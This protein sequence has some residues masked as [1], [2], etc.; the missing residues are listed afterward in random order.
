MVRIYYKDG[1]QVK[2]ETDVRELGILK[3]LMWVD[4]H[5]AS[6]EEEEWVET[7]CNISFQTPQVLILNVWN[8][9]KTH[10]WV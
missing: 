9:F 1:K 10:L 2:K 8:T 4:L 6:N 5:S 3:N 7:K